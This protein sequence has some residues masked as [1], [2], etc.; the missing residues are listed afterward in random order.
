M[1][2][3]AGL[4]PEPTWKRPSQGRSGLLSAD[5]QARAA[6]FV[7]A[8]DRRRFAHCRAAVREI[9]GSIL[10]RPRCCGSGRAD[11]ASRSWICGSRGGR[12]EWPHRMTA[13]DPVQLS[14]S[15]ELALVG[16]CRGREL[17]VDLERVRPISEAERIV[18]S[19]FSP[20]EQAEFAGIA[21]EDK[22]SHS[23]AAGPARRRF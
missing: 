13:R 22:D 6:R 8:R 4:S 19:F 14:H 12:H 17:G 2:L 3:D 15:A 11:R 9:L 1:D 20:A 23:C 7:R 18:E 16:V 10:G 21:E 5:E